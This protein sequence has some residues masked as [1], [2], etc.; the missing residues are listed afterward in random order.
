MLCEHH[1]TGQKWTTLSEIVLIPSK[2]KHIVSEREC[3]TRWLDNFS[4]K[5]SRGTVLV[6][7]WTVHSLVDNRGRMPKVS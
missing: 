4:R 6:F 7:Q 5:E 2:D 3:Y 1:L